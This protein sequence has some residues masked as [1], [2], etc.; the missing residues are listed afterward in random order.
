MHKSGLNFKIAIHYRKQVVF[1][2]VKKLVL[3]LINWTSAFPDHRRHGELIDANLA[4]ISLMICEAFWV[5]SIMKI[6]AFRLQIYSC[7]VLN[8]L[9]NS[10][11]SHLAFK[12]SDLS[13]CIYFSGDIGKFFHYSILTQ[14]Y[15]EPS[16]YL[17]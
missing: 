2:P 13:I 16:I 6:D 7:Y 12:Y 9:V 3:F 5:Y 1:S 15:D 17:N 4:S 14:L 8:I 10:F 11:T